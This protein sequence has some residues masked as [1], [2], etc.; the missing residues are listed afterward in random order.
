MTPVV[1]TQRGYQVLKLESATQTQVMPF[2]QARVGMSEMALSFWAE[3]RKVAGARTQDLLGRRWQYPT[4]REG[5]RAIL[6]QRRDGSLEGLPDVIVPPDRSK[7]AGQ[8]ITTFGAGLF[9]DTAEM[10]KH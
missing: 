5:L 1:R 4:Y 6:Q 10:R 9:D 2:E 3:N 8:L 7:G